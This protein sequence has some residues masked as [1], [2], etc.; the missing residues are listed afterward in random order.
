M[1]DLV[2]MKTEFNEQTKTMGY[3]N[4]ELV[5]EKENGRLM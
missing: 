5:L 4:K 3:K 2:I 1:D